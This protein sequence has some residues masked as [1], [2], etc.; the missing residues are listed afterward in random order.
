GV[1]VSRLVALIAEK[2]NDGSGLIW[3]REVTPADVHVVATGKQD[4]PFEAAET[5]AAD[6]EARGLTVLLDDRRGASPG[7]KFNDA[8]LI[9]VPTIAV[10]GRGIA[11]GTVEVKDRRS[12]ERS[13]VAVESAA[14]HLVELCRG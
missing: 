13:D 10:C 7:E 3:P 11:G 1:G 2:N 8:D 4:A 12:G 9:G 14:D 5:L 6:L